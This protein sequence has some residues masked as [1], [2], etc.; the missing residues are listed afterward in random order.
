MKAF[1]KSTT[2]NQFSIKL[3]GLLND[4][5]F[6]NNQRFF[7][8]SFTINTFNT[9]FLKLS[10]KYFLKNIN[11][12]IIDNKY[13]NI[14]KSTIPLS[15]S[16]EKPP[17]ELNEF[18]KN[19]KKEE[20]IFLTPEKEKAFLESKSTQFNLP[21]KT[22]TNYMEKGMLGN[23]ERIRFKDVEIYFISTI[24]D[25]INSVNLYKLLNYINPDMIQIQL[26]PD[27]IINNI[28][29]FYQKQNFIENL[30][31]EAWEI[32]PSL[33]LKERNF[34]KLLDNNILIT[35]K[36]KKEDIV[37]K[38]KSFLDLGI[39]D[40]DRLSNE[41]I[42]MISLWGEENKRKILVSDSPETF[43]VEKISNSYSVVFIREIFKNCLIQF[44]NN[45]DFEPRTILGT[46][47]NIYPDIFL[48][49]SDIFISNCINEICKLPLEKRP[50]KLVSFLG[51]GQSKSIP[52][53][54]KFNVERSSLME[55]L[56]VNKRYE[57]IIYGEDNLE[58]LVEK[59]VLLYLL[60]K[61]AGL[62]SELKLNSNNAQVDQLIRK[63]AREEMIKTGFNS[64][65]FLISRM[66]HLFD[67]LVQEKKIL[68]LEY[69]SE[70]HKLKKKMF[71][72]K[73]FNDPI[74]N[75]QLN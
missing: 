24:Y 49:L 44:P 42:S 73:I 20:Q 14:M 54:L 55:F 47:L 9:S 72:K 11:Q 33:E 28:E 13:Y 36:S 15:E 17:V 51:Y 37:E 39:Y 68:T 61:N 74:L 75:S 63:Y 26:K 8:S 23:V 43:L 62:K 32:Q 16:L 70:G 31:R 40:P 1:F 18:I 4:D 66:K 67:E 41:A 71:M 52:N 22:Y 45:P 58:I 50:K 6:I 59:W 53:Y 60:F 56:N 19:E 21:K 64:E 2:K 48:H 10:K 34:K 35:S 29:N 69:L 38:Q 12:P 3:K 7:N 57:S 25:R 5:V 65:N 30:I 46:A 27:K